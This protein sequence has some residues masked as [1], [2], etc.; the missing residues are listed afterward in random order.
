VY[1]LGKVVEF[2]HF[3]MGRVRL[4]WRRIWAVL[5]DYFVAVGKH[6][7]LRVA[8]YAVDS[9][10]QLSIKFLDRDELSKYTFQTEFLQ[11]FNTLMESKE[12]EVKELVLRCMS[13]IVAAKVNKIRS[14]WKT[15]FSVLEAAANDGNRSLVVLAFEIVERIVREHF[16]TII[17]SDRTSFISCVRCL[18]AFSKTRCSSDVS[19]NALAFMRF[20][21]LK[22]AEGL[23]GDLEEVAK[24]EETR[25]KENEEDEEP[26]DNESP[27]SSGKDQQRRSDVVTTTFTDN[28]AHVHFWFPLLE[29]LAELA[30]DV[31]S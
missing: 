29:G 30:F 31:R 7:N 3:N 13:Q 8:M 27:S 2:A 14:G 11:P 19:L 10:R 23:L 5:S 16:S 22:L 9:L 17:D 18:V 24:E 26:R 1:T 15:L 25:E 4:V 28:E 20:C 12:Y 21:A 6:S